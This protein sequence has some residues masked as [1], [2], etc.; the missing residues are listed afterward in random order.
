ML[1]LD[2][3]SVR[4]ANGAIGV[5]DVKLS[6]G[7]GEILGLVGANGAGKSTT[8]RAIS[9]YLRSEGARIIDGTIR[10]N[11]ENITNLE[12]H[13]CST[14]G[15]ALVPERTKIFPNLSV[16]DNLRAIGSSPKR[17]ERANYWDHVLDLFPVLRERL[18]QPAGQLSGGERQ[19]LGLARALANRPKLLIVDELTLGIHISIHER[20]YGTIVAIAA[21][22]VGV[23][24]VDERAPQILKISD[25]CVILRAGHVA[26]AGPAAEF[27]NLDLMAEE[28]VGSG[29]S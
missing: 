3:I 29:Q 12:P 25:Q 11:G 19:M 21:A 28:Y 10:F 17:R 23:I 18:S 20:L 26:A 14:R 1:E 4:Y 22:G 27:S 9:G 13:E 7:E 2:S 8:T 24:V 15:I 5:N 6:L 16:R